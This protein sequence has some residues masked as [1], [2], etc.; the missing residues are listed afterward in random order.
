MFRIA[1]DKSEAGQRHC[2]LKGDRD[3]VPGLKF[4]D[5][6]I[7]ERCFSNLRHESPEKG[8]PLISPSYAVVLVVLNRAL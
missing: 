2:R 5:E 3:L 7:L 8:L 6:N 1:G 4:L